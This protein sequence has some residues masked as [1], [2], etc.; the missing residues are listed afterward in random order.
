MTS[1]CVK[2]VWLIVLTML[3]GTASAAS[4]NF[5]GGSITN[6][7][8]SGSTYSCNASFSMGATDFAVI[9]SGY[10]VV[11]T[12]FSPSYNQGLTINSGGALQSSGNI[13]LSNINPGNVSTGGTTLTASGSFKLGSNTTING[14]VVAA[15]ISTNS[16]DT[17]TGSVSVSGLA[18]LGSAIKINGN[19]SAG[20]V[21]T[22]SPG[23]IGGSITATTTVALGSGLTVGGAVSGTA[24]TTT[25]PVTLNGS[26]TATVSFTLAS[27]SKVVGDIS[28]PTVTLKPSSSTV[29]GNITTT[30]ALDIGSSNTVN[31]IV[32]AGSLTMRASGATINGTTIISGD[33]DM[34]SGTVINGDLSARNVTTHASNAVINGNAAVNAIYIDWNNSVTKTIT[35]TGPGAVE[36]SCVTKADPNYKPT[37]GA[38]SAGVPHHF[39]ITHSGSALTCQPQTVTLT[40]C[41]NA[42]CTAPHFSGSVTATLS[43]GNQ[44][45]TV[46]SGTNT[47]A[48]VQSGSAGIFALSASSSGVTN[49]TTCINTGAIIGGNPCNMEFK[50]EGLT[51]T[52]TNHVSMTPASV[53]VQAL[54]AK[55]PNQSCEPLLKKQKVKVNMT[56]SYSDPTKDTVVNKATVTVGDGSM[57]CD[58]DT[59]S[60][61]LE[62]DDDGKA[63]AS[64]TYPE[65]G[66]VGLNASYST[67]AFTATGSGS[68]Y[69]A[70]SSLQLTA[71]SPL[72]AP[73]IGAATL[74]SKA[75]QLKTAFAKAGQ[76]ITV[77]VTAINAVNQRTFNFGH[78]KV[79]SD[80]D[81]V[82][83]AVNPEGGLTNGSIPKPGASSVTAAGIVN[84][85]SFDDVGVIRIK[86]QLSTDY[87]M[88]QQQE[89][90]S[91][92]TTGLQYIGRIT[93]DHF[94]TE[95]MTS[96]E[97][98]KIDAKNT[99]M[100]CNG[101]TDSSNPCKITLV[102]TSF[103]NSRQPFFMKVLARNLAG[104][105][106]QNYDGALAKVITVSAMTSNGGDEKLN[107]AADAISWSSSSAA[108]FAFT[109][110][111]GLLTNA[112][113][114]AFKFAT[115]YPT[116]EKPAVIYL[117]A[118]DND[119]VTSKRSPAEKSVE[120]PLNIVR[121]RL[122]VGNA[123]GSPTSPLKVETRAQ[124][125]MPST[126][127]VFN[128]QLNAS[129]AGAVTAYADYTNC[130]KALK[131]NDGSCKAMSVT[132]SAPLAL[133]NGLGTFKLAAPTPVITGIG[134]VDV[135]LNK[136]GDLFPYL[137]STT[138]RET[139]GVYPSGPVIY[140]REIY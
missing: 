86:P 119:N 114:P 79:R 92:R 54:K 109:K 55:A 22:D 126:G 66:L 130:Q 131:N 90:N 120:A 2:F 27:G 19:L 32:K 1:N 137:P 121:G 70:P 25:S 88:S 53:T 4:I 51:V 38:A 118:E 89:G 105:L 117:R 13:D 77:T 14:S 42:N 50:T 127:Y 78:E 123:Y 98:E 28:A 60:V 115:D 108:H 135:T 116:A 87:Y 134:S 101:L 24:I 82:L 31:G 47:A 34:E 71:T 102:T 107:S 76:D 72:G 80:I 106:T 44:P 43:P 110:G 56:C 7:P 40:A 93:P 5:N 30:G 140:T 12:G 67:S 6:C 33:V 18:D 68:F 125:Y 9:A 10:T 74:D 111:T 94:D 17:I 21:K 20:S 62:F 29:T 16:G 138:G 26:V 41:A 23:T 35:C 57:V 75:D 100:S 49:A 128:P 3:M 112:N 91:F 59:T 136:T 139:F 83:D 103:V 132:D 37:C 122:L 36:C 99:H 96:T 84:K 63:T 48:T 8:L 61:T 64:L 11:V 113:L 81:F 52:A 133:K 129:S 58:K 69:A 39:Q 73:A 15:S 65:V 124:Y 46:T 104:N 95:L 85:I 45:A 97:I